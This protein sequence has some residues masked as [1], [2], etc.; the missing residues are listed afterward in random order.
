MGNPLFGLRESLHGSGAIGLL[1][2]DGEIAIAIGLESNPFSVR[3]PDGIA[4][5]TAQRELSR[6]RGAG[7]V[8]YPEVYLLAIV[9]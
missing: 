2:E 6:R 5:C 1:P 7:K 4:I 3:R 8:D 9:C